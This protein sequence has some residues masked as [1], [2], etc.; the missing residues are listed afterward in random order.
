MV[1]VLRI[2]KELQSTNSRIEKEKIL[3]ANKGNQLFKDILQFVYDPFV[4]TGLSTKKIEKDTKLNITFEIEDI[5][6]AMKYLKENSTGKDI[7]I[8]NIQHYI[9]IHIGDEMQNF[10]KEIVT[11]DLSIGCDSKTLN[12][13]FG[14]DFTPTFD[15]MLAKSYWDY[16]NKVTDDFIITQKLDG[17]RCVLIKEN[18]SIK[19]F[20]RQGQLYIGLN[21]IESEAQYLPDNFVYDGELIALNEDNLNS[22]DLYRK[23]T[24][25]VRK[26][27]IKQ[28][29]VFH[30]FDM[31]PVKD[32]KKGYSSVSCWS[33]KAKLKYDLQALSLLW[34]K[35]V[36]VEYFGNDKSQIIYW[37]DKMIAEGHE[38]IMIN[39]AKAGYSC[40]RTSDILKVKRMQSADL[41]VLGFEEGEGKYKG[42]LGRMNVNYK[43]NT[44]GVGSGF[45]DADR[46]Y[47][48]NNQSNLIGKIAEIQYFEESTNQKDNNAV[49]LRFPVFKIFRDDKTEES[50]N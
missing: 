44:V 11:K 30:V 34:I 19:M 33:R 14:D 45:T 16:E 4:L 40:K 31:I 5:W 48:W 15:V 35:E 24:S 46:N 2:F 3:S 7:D 49:S 41:R 26:D 20:T 8:A 36:P 37:L 6:H 42:T 39:L 25:I 22:A 18:G 17:N 43:G 29:V 28:G 9:N 13:V 50:Y 10:L 47:I 23:T 21:D 27:G 12:K 32:F 1:E 38:G